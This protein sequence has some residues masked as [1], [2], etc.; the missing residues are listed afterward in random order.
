M[1]LYIFARPKKHRIAIKTHHNSIKMTKYNPYI[2]DRRSLRLKKYD[3]S[4]EGLYFITICTQNRVLLFGNIENGEMK[5]NEYGKI[6]NEEWR[7]TIAIR[8]NIIIHEYVIMPNHFHAILE[9]VRTN[10]HS[11]APEGA[12][13]IFHQNTPQQLK[14]PSQTIGS[15]VRGFKAATTRKIINNLEAD[16]I[17]SH[18]YSF[19]ENIP[20]F[21]KIW[22]RNYYEHIIRDESSHQNI[23][24]YIINNP[25]K[26]V[27]DKFYDIE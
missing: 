26:W 18:E 2:H 15:I 3:Y 24:E 11:N 9:I 23:S 5:I 12:N 16:C 25:A 1:E 27:D 7:N 19:M 17:R 13:A 8:N 6:I 4:L 20:N 22:Q 10:P 21:D 14:S